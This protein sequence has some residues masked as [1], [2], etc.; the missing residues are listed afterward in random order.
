MNNLTKLNYTTDE[1]IGDENDLLQE[2]EEITASYMCDAISEHVDRYIPMY[3]S[4][5]WKYASE[6]SE[7]IEDAIAQGL[8]EGLTDLTQIFQYGYYQYYTQ[9][10]Y[11][12]LNRIAYNVLV[13]H[14]NEIKQDWT[15]ET[16]ATIH[17]HIEYIINY[18]SDDFDINNSWDDLRE[19]LNDKI[20]ECIE[21]V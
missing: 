20:E 2:I 8:T 10:V 9:Q 15:E 3:N 1:L 6:I 19:E 16:E 17:E 11:E 14:V 5:I 21:E 4:E 12:N 18:L 13:D 7:H